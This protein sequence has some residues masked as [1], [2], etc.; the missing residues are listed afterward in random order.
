MEGPL[1]GRSMITRV[2]TSWLGPVG[3]EL[4]RA[5]PGLRLAE[6]GHG[7]VHYCLPLRGLLY[8]TEGK[9]EK[10]LSPGW[11]RASPPGDRHRIRFGLEGAECLLVFDS[12]QPGRPR[13][14][15]SES[16]RFVPLERGPALARTILEAF[17]EPDL[18]TPLVIE[19]A[20]LELSA[21]SRRPARA[22]RRPPVWLLEVREQLEADFAE[23]PSLAA[24][25][26]TANVNRSHLARAFRAHFGCSV[27]EFVRRQRLLRALRQITAGA[28]PL[29]RIASDCGFSDQSHLTRQVRA[30]TGVSP[31]ALRRRARDQSAVP[32]RAWIQSPSSSR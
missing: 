20:L 28:T 14:W 21:R 3:I 30:L 18:A 23:P 9:S 11:L 6:H 13:D 8:E 10:L 12:K 29:V 2:K 27:G 17:R 25:A 4:F 5:S 24:L 16:R 32:V 22:A 7:S 31:G 26:L 19:E 15:E 1:D